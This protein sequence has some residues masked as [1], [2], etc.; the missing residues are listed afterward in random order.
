MF[1]TPLH[2]HKTYMVSRFSVITADDTAWSC[3]LSSMNPMCTWNGNKL[4]R[5]TIHFPSLQG[6]WSPHDTHQAVKHG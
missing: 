3:R 1:P 5:Q 4:T 2:A 6:V